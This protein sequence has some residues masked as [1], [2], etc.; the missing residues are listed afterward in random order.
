MLDLDTYSVDTKKQKIKGKFV[1]REISW[2]SFNNR[3]LYCA[4]DKGLPLNE[5]LKFLGITCSNLDEFISVRY[6]GVM[7]NEDEPVSK[8]NSGIKECMKNQFKTY[9]LLKDELK[10]AGVHICKV[11]DLD[12]KEKAKI[13]NIFL[14]YIFPL[15]T[16]ISVDSTN[17]IPNFYSGQNCLCVTVKQGNI[18]KFSII[19]INKNIESMYIIDDKV[20]MIEDIILSFLNNLF[21]NK[22][23]VSCG[24]FRVIKDGS[25][26]LN[27]DTSK[28]LLDRMIDTIELRDMASPIFLQVSNDTP[29][30]LK[31]ILINVFDV[32]SHNVFSGANILDYTRFMKYKLLP[33]E[34][35]S[36][37]PFEPVPYD[38]VKEKYSIFQAIKEKDILLHHPYDSYDTVIKFIEHAANDP[39]VLAIKQTLYRV[40]SEDSPIVNALCQAARNGKFVSVLIEIKARFDEQQNIS[41]INKL[42][43]NGVNVLLGLEYLKTHCKMCIV[44][45]KEKSKMVIYSHI[46]TGNYNDKTAKMYT[47]ISYLTSKQKVGMDLL[48]I[49]NILSGI[50]TPDEKLQRVFYA[51]VNL[52]KRLLK[53]IDREISLAKKGK[54]AEIFLK[55][56]SINDPEMINK[57]YEAASKGVEVYIISRGICSIVPTKNIY[58]KSIVG[59]FLE[60]SRIYYFYNDGKPEY[61]ISSADL[62]T[63]N[64]D[65]R[66]EILLLINDQEAI[67]KL[68]EIILAFKEDKANSFKMEDNGEYKKLK[69]DFDCHKWFIESTEKNLKL[70]IA[71][72]N[73]KK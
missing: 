31:N 33:E 51:P 30:R 4:N 2:L 10:K 23:I 34:K 62:L 63:R 18:E 7:K 59:R 64:L 1:N 41:L 13:K 44:V 25:V 17:E 45:R 21:I 53:N 71:K 26:I 42:K 39:D 9:E 54:H 3:V 6:A 61:Y 67:K 49:F 60:H 40:S 58:I 72:R 69:G 38:F 12:K 32:D 11:K 14:S 8:I 28:F 48:H 65:R 55:L 22:E 56:N 68:K 16:P 52:R 50:S 29:K 57:L 46:G 70:K 36:Y 19:P 5:R 43:R 27:H 47:D 37:K 73:K 20:I 35:Y 24:Y 66:V 15:L